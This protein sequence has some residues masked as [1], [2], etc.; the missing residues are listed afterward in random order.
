MSFNVVRQVIR[1]LVIIT[2]TLIFS[3]LAL[4]TYLTISFNQFSQQ[5]HENFTE[6]I[7]E[8]ISF[9]SPHDV[10]AFQYQELLRKLNTPQFFG[11]LPDLVM[12]IVLAVVVGTLG[13]LAGLIKLVVID[14]KSSISVC[15]NTLLGGFS[16]FVVFLMASAVPY[17]LTPTKPSLDLAAIVFLSLVGGMFPRYLF[18][19][20]ENFSKKCWE[21]MLGGKK[22]NG[23]KGLK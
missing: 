1:P 18:D 14:E 23:N 8:G 15:Y 17:I 16:G 11:S 9:Q 20:I 19:G 2:L 22:G 5:T 3:Y 4:V 10:K 7:F 6:T 21:K 13:S 12:Q